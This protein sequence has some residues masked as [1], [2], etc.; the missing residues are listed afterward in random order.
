[1][2]S[3][4]PVPFAHGRKDWMTPA[5]LTHYWLHRTTPTHNNT[6]PASR[7]T[8]NHKDGMLYLCASKYE[9]YFGLTLTL[10]PCW[11]MPLSCFASSGVRE[12]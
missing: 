1:M 8:L 2:K 5:S 10:S 6:T 7:A 11:T 4:L 9:V 3:G 12:A